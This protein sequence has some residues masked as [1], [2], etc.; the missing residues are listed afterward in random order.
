MCLE[1]DEKKVASEEVSDLPSK[2][3]DVVA[4]QGKT[5]ALVTSQG[6]GLWAVCFDHT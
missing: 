1:T 3:E 6:A 2:L 4:K 5:V